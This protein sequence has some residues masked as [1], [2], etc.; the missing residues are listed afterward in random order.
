MWQKLELQRRQ[1]AFEREKLIKA[2]EK[3]AAKHLQ[4][5]EE[6][7]EQREKIKVLSHVAF[8]ESFSG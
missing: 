3:K 4:S 1:I 5:F 6:A 7:E 8:V 2:E